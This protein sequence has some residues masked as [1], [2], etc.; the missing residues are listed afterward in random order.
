MPNEANPLKFRALWLPCG[1][2]NFER[3]RINF[4][5]LRLDS[6]KPLVERLERHGELGRILRS[7]D[8]NLRFV[9]FTAGCDEGTS[10]YYADS[11][12]FICALG[13]EP[14]MLRLA[15]ESYCVHRSGDPGL[16]WSEEWA[17][18]AFQAN[19]L[20]EG[21]WNS[22][23]DP[24][25]FLLTNEERRAKVEGAFTFGELQA[26]LIESG[27]Y[28]WP[29]NE[30]EP[31]PWSL[32]ARI[33]VCA[34]R[35]FRNDH[36]LPLKWNIEAARRRLFAET[37]TLL[38][39]QES[40]HQFAITYQEH[41]PGEP[42]VSRDG[43]FENTSDAQLRG[44]VLLVSAK[45]PLLDNLNYLA[46]EAMNDILADA[47]EPVGRRSPELAVLGQVVHSL[48]RLSVALKENVNTLENSF[49]AAWRDAMFHET[50]Q[51]RVEEEALGELQR[52]AGQETEGRWFETFLLVLTLAATIVVLMDAVG[53]KEGG[54]GDSG[55][56]TGKGPGHPAS[57]IVSQLA[58]HV[59][60]LGW[61]FGFVAG[62][63]VLAYLIAVAVRLLAHGFVPRYEQ[64]TR[65][66]EPIGHPA[67]NR[68]TTAGPARS[69][70]PRHRK[71]AIGYKWKAK[72][73]KAPGLKASRC[74]W[75]IGT[76]HGIVDGLSRIGVEEL[77]NIRFAALSRAEIQRARVDTPSDADSFMRLHLAFTFL[78]SKPQSLW[79]RATFRNHRYWGGV[80][81]SVFYGFTGW[82]YRILI[83]LSR[84]LPARRADIQ[85]AIELHRHWPDQ[86]VPAMLF[87]R[88]VRTI[89]VSREHVTLNQ[90][91]ALIHFLDSVVLQQLLPE[92]RRQQE[93]AW[94]TT[95]GQQSLLARSADVAMPRR[96]RPTRL[97]LLADR[98]FVTGSDENVTFLRDS[99][100]RPAGSAENGVRPPGTSNGTAPAS[101]GR[102]LFVR[103][104]AGILGRLRRD[105][106]TRNSKAGRN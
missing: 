106:V 61:P 49:E 41:Q 83:K 80:P 46:E 98:I 70:R 77:G 31:L 54:G 53:K 63:A 59:H 65:L 14:R 37:M 58:G 72:D 10:W 28:L 102:L 45:I 44:Y 64:V 42:I 97:S 26:P 88:E 20:F 85:C 23:F 21:I 56:T 91:A 71:P 100:V 43:F 48:R 8:V 93:S 39:R 68:E 81:L 90:S 40:L 3:E 4:D 60:Q 52:E 99:R 51:V 35:S 84:T 11:D 13:T 18:T 101:N 66:D 16:A 79:L 12:G 87:V 76:Y 95:L 6:E 94:S 92:Y 25:V 5:A 19:L 29:L 32:R 96:D 1:V 57:G 103:P 27:E 82:L 75:G 89:V 22:A 73:I 15:D 30:E 86:K 67:D 2:Q 36:L 104:L 47:G 17:M 50:E 38:H 62:F 105:N 9:W 69:D 34:M 78:L 7:T 55:G 24:A 74:L 33:L